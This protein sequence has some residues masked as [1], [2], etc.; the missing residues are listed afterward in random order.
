[1][2]KKLVVSLFGALLCISPFLYSHEG[3]EEHASNFINWI[4]SFHPILLHFPIA[5]VTMT[6]VAE[7]FARLRDKQSYD[8]AARFMINAAAI[9]VIPTIIC[10]WA[11]SYGMDYSGDLQNTFWWHRFFGIT[12]GVL[13]ITTAYFRRRSAN[14][15]YLLLLTATILSVATTGYLGGT[16][17]FGS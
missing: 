4:G 10:G 2:S 6:G 9:F 15:T 7:C 16:L 5:L 14:T 12:T 3:H 8:D 13:L 1:M 17:T 11:L